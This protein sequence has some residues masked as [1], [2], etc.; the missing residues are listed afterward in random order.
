MKA[1]IL[2]ADLEDYPGMYLDLNETQ[3]GL[4]GVYAPYPTN[5]HVVQRNLVPTER[6]AYIAKTNGARS[7]PWRVVAISGQD[8]ELLNNDIIQKLAS[9]P[10]IMD[11]SWVKPGLVAWDWWNN[12]NVTGVDFK[13][14]INTETY[15][16]YI[17]FAAANKL[18]YI[19]MDEGWSEFYDLIKI[20]PNNKLI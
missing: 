11:Y 18:S 15:K 10:R 20:R 13:A 2:E 14:G 16:Y 19:V 1:E 4:K 12:W 17:D 7:F 6:A 8:K 3:K 9:S 5:A